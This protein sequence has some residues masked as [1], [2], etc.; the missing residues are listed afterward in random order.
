MQFASFKTCKAIM[1]ILES[2]GATSGNT[3]RFKDSSLILKPCRKQTSFPRLMVG[4]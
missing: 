3:S 1:Q 4:F 2:V